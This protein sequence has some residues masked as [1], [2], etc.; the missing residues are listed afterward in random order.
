MKLYFQ[1]SNG[2]LSLVTEQTSME[3]IIS[4]A[5]KDLK[6][7]S[8]NYRTYYQ[9]VWTDN[10]NWTWVDVGSHTEFYIGIED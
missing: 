4:D 3:T 1:H 9:R 7:R 6:V 2:S 8:P 5:L 10:N